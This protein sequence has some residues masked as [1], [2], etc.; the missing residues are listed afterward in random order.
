MCTAD[1][2][3]TVPS[4]SVQLPDSQKAEL[5]SYTKHSISQ[6]ASQASKQS[7]QHEELSPLSSR[8]TKHQRE[9][10]LGWSVKEAPQG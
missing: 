6:A 9:A 5:L 2:V 1:T 3:A 10:G 8:L 7:E 4:H